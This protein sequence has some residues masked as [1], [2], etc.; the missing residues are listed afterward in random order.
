M[1][2]ILLTIF[3][4]LAISNTFASD[5]S[6]V[7]EKGLV[8]EQPDGYL[9]LIDKSADDKVKALIAEV[10]SKRKAVYL[11]IAKKR[12]LDLAQIEKISG[13]QNIEKTEK[14]NFVFVGGKWQKK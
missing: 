12:K 14:G 3:L 11:G 5:L 6:V 13:K 4:A 10:N 8:G 9:G 1:K 2:T 7:K